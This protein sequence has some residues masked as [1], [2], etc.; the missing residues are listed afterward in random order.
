MH[1]GIDASS[2]GDG[3]GLHHLQQLLQAVDL[4]AHRIQVTVWAADRVCAT[5]TPR[6]GITIVRIP[7]A[8][9]S[10]FGRFLWQ[11]RTLHHLA[12]DAQCDVLF[13]PGGTYLGPFRPFVTMSRNL[14][15]FEP[16][17]RKRFGWSRRRVRYLLLEK[18]L[19]ATLRRADAAIHLTETARE[20]VEKRIGRANLR[21]VVI[22]HG[23]TESFRR[24]A[25]VQLPLSEFSKERP[26]RWIYVSIVNWYKHQWHVVEAVG[27][28]RRRGYP[29]ELRIVGPAYAPALERLLATMNRVDPLGSFVRY[30]GDARHDAIPRLYDESEGALIASS[31]ETFGQV[32]VEAMAA[33]L[34]V[35]CS[36]R[37]ALPEVLGTS[38]EFFDPEDP[39]DIA[40]ALATMMDSP[41]YRARA[42]A[43]ALERSAALTWDA[44]A[45]ATF[46]L[47]G[48]VAADAQAAG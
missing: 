5:L 47:L 10:G 26:F 4:V 41:D 48:S 46:R 36:N 8:S 16:A 9:A 18:T 27:M 17:E 28:L 33:G 43:A 35:A 34:P 44:C 13:V 1:I 32:L 23:V 24:A 15:P 3:G 7:D 38:G 45:H 12:H 30:E 22:P 37:S 11:Q 19:A 39:N 29:V 31:C 20:I 2:L 21:S 40:R 6:K 25:R 14:L 42:V